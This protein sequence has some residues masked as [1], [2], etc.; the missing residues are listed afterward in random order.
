MNNISVKNQRCDAMPNV[1]YAQIQKDEIL[2]MF[3]YIIYNRI[4]LNS[5]LKFMLK[6]LKES[7]EGIGTDTVFRVKS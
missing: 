1:L 3:A 2:H 4:I 6:I 7:I 5:H